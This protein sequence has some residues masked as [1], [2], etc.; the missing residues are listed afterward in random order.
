MLIDAF[1]CHEPSRI[2]LHVLEGLLQGSSFDW[3]PED[4]IIAVVIR[5][6]EVNASHCCLRLRKGR[7]KEI[8]SLITK[9]D[10]PH[11]FRFYPDLMLNAAMQDKTRGSVLC[12]LSV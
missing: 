7:H 11:P 1:V 10:T 4:A 9:Q 2:S 6:Q 5:R 8:Q 3:H 12:S